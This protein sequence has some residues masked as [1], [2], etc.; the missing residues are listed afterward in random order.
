LAIPHKTG[1]HYSVTSR[2]PVASDT[3]SNEFWEN[4]LKNFINQ[5]EFIVVDTPHD[6]SDSAIQILNVSTNILLLMGP[7]LSSLRCAANALDVYGR[8]GIPPERVK[9]I[10]NMI[11][12]QS[13]IKQAQFEKA[14]DYPISY[15][16]PYDAEE[17]IRA[18]NFGEPFILSNHDLPISVTIEDIAYDL[19]DES[20]KSIPP[21]APSDAWKRVSQ[22]NSSKKK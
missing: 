22:R 11:T 5:N 13:G 12:N 2:L 7:D 6:F 3:F 15:I 17:V 16:I 10:L 18:I 19:S 14:L 8:I 21:A 4:L 9:I 20:Y 1:I